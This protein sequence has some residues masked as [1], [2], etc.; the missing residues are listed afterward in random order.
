LPK[1]ATQYDLA[2][3]EGD[4]GHDDCFCAVKKEPDQL[5]E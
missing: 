2:G 4:G 3:I 5:V 1:V